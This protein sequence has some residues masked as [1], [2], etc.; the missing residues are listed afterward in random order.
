MTAPNTE[1]N[2][3]PASGPDP[4]LPEPPPPRRPR[5]YDLRTELLI[6]A[7]LVA[8]SAVLGLLM[9]LLWHLVAPKVPLYADTSAIYLLDPEGEQAISSDMYFAMIGAGFGLLVGALAYWRSRAREGGLTVVVGLVLGGL[10]GG[11]IAMKLG[12]ALGPSSNIVAT[13]KAVPLGR[14]FYA[15][16]TLTA[17][18]MLLAWP[19]AA[20]IALTVLTSL[21]TPKP[22]PS[23]V[24]WGNQL[25]DRSDTL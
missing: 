21:F 10:L 22:T 19:A 1:S 14:T 3:G 7:S 17:K 16:L 23:P 4:E 6:G 11:W 13:A 5:R 18:G 2:S 24:E 15:P 20:L 9:G 25:K 12:V 8:G